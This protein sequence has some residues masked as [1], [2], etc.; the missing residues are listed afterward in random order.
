[1][2]WNPN[3]TFTTRKSAFPFL[4]EWVEEMWRIYS[5]E[6]VGEPRLGGVDFSANDQQHGVGL[7]TR[8]KPNGAHREAGRSG[9]IG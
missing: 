6:S 9:A 7:L 4:G 3:A 2:L 1:M 5:H 8:W